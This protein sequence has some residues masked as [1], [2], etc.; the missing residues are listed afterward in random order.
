MRIS[1]RHSFILFSN[2]KTGSSTTRQYFDRYSDVKP[3]GSYA[4]RT[5]ENLFY[6]HITPRETREIFKLYGW[7]FEKYRKFVFVRNPW[8]RLVSL[9]EHINRVASTKHVFHEWIYTIKNRG[10][11]GGGE[12]S[13][14]WRRYGAWS[15]EHYIS[16]ESG[17][18][19]VDDI[20][21]MEDMATCL[22]PFMQ[23]LG[24][25]SKLAGQIPFSNRGGYRRHYR[26][27][28]NDESRQYVAQSYRFDIENFGYRFE[29]K[30]GSEK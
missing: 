28:Y 16:D 20:L 2:P 11:G 10:I 29:E 19:L 6:P 5:A 24:L 23:S 13:C 15:I 21:R 26:D 4:D 30:G 18:S 14:R 1:H 9:F 27:Y 12:T 8:A 25:D 17:N 22:P 3:I 7:D